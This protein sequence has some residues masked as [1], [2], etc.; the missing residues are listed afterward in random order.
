MNSRRDTVYKQLFSHPEIVRD[1]VVGLLP[2]DWAQSL[3]VGTFERV[4]ASYT[5]DE[6]K[7]RHQDVVW[8]A[9]IG[10]EWVYVYVLL[11]FQSRSDKWMALRMQVYIGLLYQELVTQRKLSK[12]GKLP[13][14]LPIVLYH[15]HRPW[16]AA[17][18][19]AQ[20]MLPAPAGLERFQANQQYLLIDQHHD[21]ARGNIMPLLFRLL[22]SRTGADMRAN[23]AAFSE[24]L[25]QPDLACVRDSLTHWLLLTLHER[26][27][28]ITMY[29]EEGLVM[30]SDK[31]FNFRDVIT[32][33]F[34]RKLLQPHEASLQEGVQQGMQQGMQQGERQ[35]LQEVLTDLLLAD[36]MTA[37]V[38]PKIAKADNS[39]LRAWI[40]SLI[41][42]VSPRQLFAE[43]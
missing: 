20:L 10:G 36:G 34:V 24:R 6:G 38:A 16:R 13:P 41:G 32:E 31:S 2:A 28:D 4:N 7:L 18:E 19:L 11:E 39:Q 33:D 8:R 35:A 30:R 15:G 21:A 25:R 23:L 1:L 27:D 42:G 29:S 12:Y 43:G 37:D 40:K 14:V 17:T 22:Y 5:S 3:A 26:K 9:R